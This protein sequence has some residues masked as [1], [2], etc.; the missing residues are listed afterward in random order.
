MTQNKKGRKK[1]NNPKKTWLKV[2]VT[3]QMYAM[4][5]E[6]N[7]SQMINEGLAILMPTLGQK[8][9]GE[10]WIPWEHEG[11][12]ANLVAHK[13]ICY[14]IETIIDNRFKI[15]EAYR[16]KAKEGDPYYPTKFFGN[17]E[18]E[19]LGLLEK[20]KKELESHSTFCKV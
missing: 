13:A 4:L 15:L 1:S 12:A 9:D 2:R 20:Q 18:T 10:K 17:S 5:K 6:A 7:K 19:L 8:W 11:T 14:A 16:A 3:D